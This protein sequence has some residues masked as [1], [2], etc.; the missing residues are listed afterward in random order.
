MLL[1][2]NGLLHTM[3][4][5]QPVFADLLIRDGKIAKIA[6]SLTPGG[7]TTILDATGLHVF[8][9]FIDAHSHIGIS[10]EKV[11]GIGDE[12]NENNT[13]AT[14][15]LRAIDCIHPMDSA[16]HN[17]IAAGITSVMAGPGSANPIGG[18]FAFIKTDGR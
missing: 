17:A 2:K 7:H 6:P 4:T 15:Y 14:P 3:E 9:G 5:E 11:T 10:E 1:I 16:F 12:C 8:P 13:P 18:Q